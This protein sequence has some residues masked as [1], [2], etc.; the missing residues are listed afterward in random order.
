[1]QG[2]FYFFLLACI[3]KGSDTL[4]QSQSLV[5]NSTSPLTITVQCSYIYIHAFIAKFALFYRKYHK[6]IQN[7][8][9][10]MEQTL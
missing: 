8:L 5:Y 7:N 2:I 3:H 6:T 10:C 4:Y 9:I 1:M